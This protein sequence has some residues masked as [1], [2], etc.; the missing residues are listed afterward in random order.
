MQETI[1][2]I[3]VEIKDINMGICSQMNTI[4][5]DVA[6]I[7]LNISTLTS[8]YCSKFTPLGMRIN[9]TYMLD[10]TLKTASNFVE[11]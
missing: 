10:Y 4:Y 2:E 1:G 5:Q 6:E 9:W 7:N 11:N 3:Q 8:I